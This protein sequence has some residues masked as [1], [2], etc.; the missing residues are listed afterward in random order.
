MDKE[1]WI[2]DFVKWMLENSMDT[3]KE[4]AKKL[5]AKYT[6]FSGS[7]L[8]DRIVYGE[9]IFENDVGLSEEVFSSI[10]GVE[11]LLKEKLLT[12]EVISLIASQIYCIIFI[13]A[14]YDTSLEDE[15]M[16]IRILLVLGISTG[17]DKVKKAIMEHGECSAKDLIEKYLEGGLIKL[18]RDISSTM[19]LKISKSRL[20]RKIPLIAIPVSAGLNYLNL[21]I[22][23]KAAKYYFNDLQYDAGEITE[24][25]LLKY[26]QARAI[27]SLMMYMARADNVYKEVEK[28]IIEVVKDNIYVPE[29]YKDDFEKAIKEEPD[30]TEI[31]KIIK[32]K[33]A[34]KAVLIQLFLVMY[35]DDELH[36]DEVRIID[37]IGEKLGIAK[38]DIK[39]VE[40]KI[41]TLKWFNKGLAFTEKGEYNRALQC[42]DNTLELAPKDIDTLNKKA[43][44][45]YKMKKYNDAVKW[46]DK[47][48]KIEPKNKFSWNNKGLALYNQEK[49]EEALSCYDNAVRIDSDYKYAW[50]NRG[51]VLYKLDRYDEAIKCYDRLLEIN[52]EN[53]DAV[54]KK[55]EVLKKTGNSI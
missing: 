41:L 44:I 28:D 43:N 6:T 31:K 7:D 47:A 19:I 45:L 54:N 3:V 25:E 1:I 40:K 42:Y 18:L 24:L 10:P 29:L 53:K 15:D 48:I 5:K 26:K 46:Y 52:P 8:V 9:A 21:S 16:I 32:L 4:K 37:E 12:P 22:A 35:F 23:G 30:W 55:E 34:K 36:L 27:V 20:L 13:A 33:E 51:M 2:Y 39:A 50:M 11:K 14:L 17:L 38:K 49:Y